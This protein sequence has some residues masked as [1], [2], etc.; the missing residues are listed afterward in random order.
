MPPEGDKRVRGRSAEGQARSQRGSRPLAGDSSWSGA[1]C[2]AE[3]CAEAAWISA[4]DS[5]R[6]QQEWEKRRWFCLG[7]KYV[8]LPLRCELVRRW[9]QIESSASG[10]LLE[11]DEKT[12]DR[13]V[14]IA[15]LK[16][17]ELFHYA[18]EQPLPTPSVSAWVM[19]S[20]QPTAVARW[21]EIDTMPKLR[22]IRAD[23]FRLYP[24]LVRELLTVLWWIDGCDINDMP[25]ELATTKGMRH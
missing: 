15:K 11:L 12:H 14:R 4:S 25:R 21:A 17:V 22:R 23:L 5:P 7:G 13:E 20:Y 1:S 9:E 8:V 10:G 3:P 16:L 24:E 6:Q 2:A 19:W 18:H